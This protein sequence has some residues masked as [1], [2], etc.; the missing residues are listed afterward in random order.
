MWFRRRRRRPP[1]PPP[2]CP[3]CG[4]STVLAGRFCRAC[5]WD[6]D[7]AE[8]PDAHLDG[9][10]VPTGYGREEEEP[11]PTARGNFLLVAAV[12]ALVSFLLAL[13]AESG[14]AW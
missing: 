10:D 1:P 8:S 14:I 11:A 13:L 6:A 3:L 9:V 7:L 5:G 2:P 4:K 12:L